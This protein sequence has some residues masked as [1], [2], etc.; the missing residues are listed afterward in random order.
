M[1]FEWLPAKNYKRHYIC[2]DCQKGYKRPSKEDM[3]EE[4]KG[5][6]PHNLM[7]LYY[8]SDRKEDILQYIH[9]TY[10]NHKVP[11]PQCQQP[12][13]E[14]SY[15]FKVPKQRDN[16][17]WKELKTYFGNKAKPNYER[18]IKWHQWQLDRKEKAYQSLLPLIQQNLRL[19]EQSKK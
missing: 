1:G 3:K 6:V 11:C 14:V 7:E 12:M 13:L 17:T 18:Y 16:K 15:V 5:T 9:A 8:A 19:L 10:Q 2:L 4:E